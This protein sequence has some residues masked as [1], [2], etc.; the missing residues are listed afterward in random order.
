[1]DHLVRE[2]MQEYGAVAFGVVSA[3][4]LM[5]VIVG[6]I[7]KVWQTM[8]SPVLK[9]SEAGQ[10]AMVE[11]SRNVQSGAEA[12]ERAAASHVEA[13]R[14]TR[15]MVSEQGELVKTMRSLAADMRDIHK[16]QTNGRSS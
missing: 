11:A 16:E 2:F 13:V 3:V 1:M 4:I 8:V 12:L 6:A 5:L 15:G 7:L 9:V 14:Q 10:K